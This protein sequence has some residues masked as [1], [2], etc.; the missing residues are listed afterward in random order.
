MSINV[1]CDCG[2]TLKVKDD[3]AG[4]KIKCP[5]CQTVLVVPAADEAPLSDVGKKSSA[6]EDLGGDDDGG[7]IVKKKKKDSKK[8]LIFGLIGGFVLLSCCCVG[9]SGGVWFA[10][11]RGGP[12]KAIIGK[13]TVDV[14][15]LKK[16]PPKQLK[17]A[18]DQLD[19]LPPDIKEKA[20]M[21][22][23]KMMDSMKDF[24]VEFKS[25]NTMSMTVPG[26]KTPETSKWKVLSSKD[27]VLTI[28][29][30]PDKTKKTDTGKIKIIDRDHIQL[31]MTDGG[32]PDLVMKRLP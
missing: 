24:T 5:A 7:K 23:D 18:L 4:K 8:L 3:A 12:E 25:D 13:W 29:I 9:V 31:I 10:F 17:D 2:K 16:N 21:V 1:V 11:L 22:T 14:E 32:M 15:A 26:S 20:K 6:F 28:E 30:T 27:D 19:K